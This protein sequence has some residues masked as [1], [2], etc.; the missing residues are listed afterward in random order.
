MP[1]GR[2]CSRSRQIAREP[3]RL[4]H[5]AADLVGGLARESLAL[6]W[7]APRAE[8]DLSAVDSG[9]GETFVRP[10]HVRVPAVVL[11]EPCRSKPR[12]ERA[13]RLARMGAWADPDAQIPGVDPLRSLDNKRFGDQA[14][15]FASDDVGVR[16][17][18]IER[19]LDLLVVLLARGLDELQLVCAVGRYIGVSDQ[20]TGA[21]NRLCV[22]VEGDLEQP[23][24][25]VLVRLDLA[26][27]A[28]TATR[29]DAY[30][31]I[32]A[33]GRPHSERVS[34]CCPR[35]P[36]GCAR[37]AFLPGQLE[38]I[39]R[40]H[41]VVTLGLIA[42]VPLAPLGMFVYTRVASVDGPEAKAANERLIESI[43]P[44]PG[45]RRQGPFQHYERRKWQGEALVPVAGYKTD[46]YYSVRDRVAQPAL[47]AHFDRQLRGWRRRDEFV[48]C[49]TLGLEPD[50][51]GG[52][53]L[54]Y[55]RSGVRLTLDTSDFRRNGPLDPPTYGLYV[56]Q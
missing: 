26:H 25:A 23:I 52:H 36:Y 37:P 6:P 1:S 48:D 56:S 22:R 43:A 42:L 13:H 5:P 18:D 41:T 11:D 35:N 3:A 47:I 16:I 28:D 50:C 31:V 53:V 40:L 14:L 10:R 15:H 20:E 19:E 51:G 9:D 45:S 24:V 34:D 17:R 8:K 12:H 32:R 46:T 33:K 4:I 39:D 29:P 38:V 49:A 7:V 27:L 30:V 21:G 44:F 54:T 2:S 55:E